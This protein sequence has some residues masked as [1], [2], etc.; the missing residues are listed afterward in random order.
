MKNYFQ[1]HTLWKVFGAKNRKEYL[2]KYVIEGRFHSAV[3]QD[4]VEAYITAEYIM[5]H[6]YYHWAMY[7][8][9]PNKI[10][11]IFEMAVKLLAKEKEI[12]LTITT[13]RGKV[14]DKKLYDLI[15][16]V[17]QGEHLSS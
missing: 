14:K 8:E 15:E 2:E 9:A 7:D 12:P 16:E 13:R 11:R 10:Y 1:P 3:P 17:C 5:A 4:V 6:A